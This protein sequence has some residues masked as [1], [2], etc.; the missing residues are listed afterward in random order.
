MSKYKNYK[1]ICENSLCNH[2]EEIEDDNID[3]IKNKYKTC[4]ICGDIM[5]IIFIDENSSEE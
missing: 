3:V 5:Q 1:Y 2:E 4:S